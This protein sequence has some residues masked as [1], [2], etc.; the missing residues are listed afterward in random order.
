MPNCCFS[1]VLPQIELRIMKILLSWFMPHSDYLTSLDT[2]VST[3]KGTNYITF[4]HNI[5]WFQLLNSKNSIQLVK[6]ISVIT[7]PNK[8]NNSEFQF[9]LYQTLKKTFACL[10]RREG[11]LLWCCLSVGRSACP[12]IVPRGWTCWNVW[13]TGLSW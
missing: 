6:M 1:I 11:I 10:V 9:L 8:L 3:N 7:C 2:S 12:P 5:L 4:T 13:Y